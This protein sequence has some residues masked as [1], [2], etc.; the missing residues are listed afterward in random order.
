MS[1][2][3]PAHGPSSGWFQLGIVSLICVPSNLPSSVRKICVDGGNRYWPG[4]SGHVGPGVLEVLKVPLESEPDSDY[5]DEAK[6]RQ[7][8]CGK[9]HAQLHTDRGASHVDGGKCDCMRTE[10]DANDF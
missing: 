6:S 9:Q 8:G 10:S 2:R 4:R 7:F 5:D 3:V 1:E